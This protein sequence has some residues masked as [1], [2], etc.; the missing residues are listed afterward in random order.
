[1]RAN[2]WY[3]R[4][5]LTHAKVIDNK[6]KRHDRLIQK[7]NIWKKEQTSYS[8]IIGMNCRGDRTCVTQH[9]SIQEKGSCKYKI[10]SCTFQSLIMSTCRRSSVICDD[11]TWTIPTT[12]MNELCLHP[13]VV[14]TFF[15]M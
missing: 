15:K 11:K 5:L 13:V 12:N 3:D 9:A 10:I 8:I 4:S 14:L 6:C 1:M 7:R 2:L